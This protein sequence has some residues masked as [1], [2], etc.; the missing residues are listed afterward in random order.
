M[1]GSTR[2]RSPGR[3]MVL[4][5]TALLLPK[6]PRQQRGSI[7]VDCDDEVE[8]SLDLD[9]YLQHAHRLSSR[10]L[11]SLGG[12]LISRQ[13]MDEGIRLLTDIVGD[14]ESGRRAD[15]GGWYADALLNHGIALSMVL[16]NE[17]MRRVCHPHVLGGCY[18]VLKGGP[19]VPRA[20]QSEWLR[21]RGG[22]RGK[23]SVSAPGL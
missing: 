1:S 13:R 18:F 9:L 21:S 17:V 23:L 14:C 8:D 20:G 12:A 5:P 16:N 7:S 2:H 4:G 6:K 15:E 22:K 10:D 3:K 11:C 19:G